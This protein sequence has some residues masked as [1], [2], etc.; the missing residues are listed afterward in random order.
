MILILAFFMAPQVP[1]TL[2]IAFSIFCSLCYPY[3]IIFIDTSSSSQ[4]IF[5]VISILLWILFRELWFLSFG[6][7]IF[8]LQILFLYLLFSKTFWLLVHFKSVLLVGTFYICIISAL[9]CIDGLFP[10]EVRF[11]WLFVCWVIR[12]Q[13]VISP[14]VLIYGS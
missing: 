10:Y 7:C 1:E 5:S 6:Y 3:H 14:T 12:L 8:Q 2:S 4:I 13:Y 11:S 9:M